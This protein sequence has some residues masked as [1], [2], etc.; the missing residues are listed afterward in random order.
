MTVLNK[1]IATINNPCSGSTP[2][3]TCG[4]NNAAMINVYTGKRAEQVING[5]TIIVSIRSRRR[6]IVRVAMIAGTA[7]A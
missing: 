1:Y 7:Q 5:M 4:G 2:K 6:S 3:T